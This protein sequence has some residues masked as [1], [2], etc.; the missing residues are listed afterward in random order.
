MK[1]VICDTPCHLTAIDTAKLK[2]TVDFFLNMRW[3]D[4]RIEFRDLNDI[5]ALNSLSNNDKENIWVPQL[6][7]VNALGATQ[8]SPIIHQSYM[9]PK[10]FLETLLRTRS[11]LVRPR[12]PS[13]TPAC[14]ASVNPSP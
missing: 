5:R 10:N 2:Y 13:V 8:A 7:F 11:L 14:S 1:I 4:L 9:Y 6:D 12:I 3:Y